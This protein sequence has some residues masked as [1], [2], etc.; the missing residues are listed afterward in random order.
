MPSVAPQSGS[1]AGLAEDL[2][3]LQYPEVGVLA[4]PTQYLF[5]A[6]N[7]SWTSSALRN[8]SSLAW[9]A[10]VAVVPLSISVQVDAQLGPAPGHS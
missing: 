3:H 2:V 9:S 7:W 5:P 6:V 10:T 8:W 4:N 1:E